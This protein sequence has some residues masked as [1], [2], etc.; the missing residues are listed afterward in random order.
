MK[1]HQRMASRL[2]RLSLRGSSA[3]Q[4]RGRYLAPPAVAASPVAQANVQGGSREP[5]DLAR[6]HRPFRLP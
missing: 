2:A 5:S 3:A 6:P 4:T 1:A